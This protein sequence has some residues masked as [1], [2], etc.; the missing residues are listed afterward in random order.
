MV[1]KSQWEG[2]LWAWE[3]GDLQVP[4]ED[5][6]PAMACHGPEDTLQLSDR[7]HVCDFGATPG[8]AHAS[9][10][11]SWASCLPGLGT[12][13]QEMKTGPVGAFSPPPSHHLWVGDWHEVS[14]VHQVM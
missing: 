13:V 14:A 7:V 6:V 2:E 12:S 11:I 1:Q 5:S 3:L 9:L 8:S 10:G 4:T